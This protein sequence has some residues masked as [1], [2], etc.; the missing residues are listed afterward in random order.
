[1]VAPRIAVVQ[2]SLT[3][4]QEHVDGRAATHI[5]GVTFYG[6]MLHEHMAIADVVKTTFPQATA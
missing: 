3:D 4:G 2:G 5:T 6:F 1:M